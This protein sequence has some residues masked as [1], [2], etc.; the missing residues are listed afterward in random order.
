MSSNWDIWSDGLM[1]YEY[2]FGTIY[3]YYFINQSHPIIDELNCTA[4]DTA[5]AGNVTFYI[6]NCFKTERLL[7]VLTLIPIFLPGLLLTFLIARGLRKRQHIIYSIIF[8]ALTP[9]ICAS[10]PLLVLA[11]KVIK[12]IILFDSISEPLLILFFLHYLD[13]ISGTYWWGIQKIKWSNWILRS[14][15]RIHTSSCITNC[16]PF[17]CFYWKK[18]SISFHLPFNSNIYHNDNVCRY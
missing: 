17:C 15:H 13:N 7:G 9:M 16:C 6:Y 5:V 12:K 2:N 3:V 1:W 18:N 4:I 10:F 11:T 14:C 8:L